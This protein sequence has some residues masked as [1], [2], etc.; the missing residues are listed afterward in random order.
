MGVRETEQLAARARPPYRLL[1]ETFN[2]PTSYPTG[3]YTYT[4][5][6]FK[7][8]ERATALQGMNGFTAEVVTGSISGNSFKLKVFTG[9]STGPVEVTNGSNISNLAFTVL[10]EGI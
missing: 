3:G 10:V 8:I 5:R 4:S 7:H 1:T 9:T 2:G 6:V